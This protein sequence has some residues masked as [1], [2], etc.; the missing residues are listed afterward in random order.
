MREVTIA[1]ARCCISL[2]KHDSN[3]EELPDHYRGRV[4]P[5]AK[6]T[7]LQSPRMPPLT[8]VHHCMMLLEE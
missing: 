1:P 7:F 5:D 4:L 2:L 6:V 3:P 8:R